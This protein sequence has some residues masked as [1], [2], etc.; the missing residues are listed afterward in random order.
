MKELFLPPSTR[1]QGEN[2]N[3]TKVDKYPNPH[4]VKTHLPKNPQ[5]ENRTVCK[6]LIL[7]VI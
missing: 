3:P 7:T 5:A 1:P 6:T 2:T 4:T